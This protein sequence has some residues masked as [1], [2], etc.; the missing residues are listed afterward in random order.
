MNRHRISLK[1][2]KILL[3]I[4]GLTL[5]LITAAI[6]PNNS[7]AQEHRLVKPEWVMPE[8]YPEWFHGWGRIGYID[9]DKIVIN[10]FEFRLS[11]Y[12]EYHTPT[13]AY[14]RKALFTPGKLVGFLFNEE[15]EI[16]SLWLITMEK[17]RK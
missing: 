7:S 1:T 17:Q 9:E 15:D 4:S 14:A 12:V 2:M 3:T 5:F 6:P 10:D 13:S 8:S 16:T 11:P